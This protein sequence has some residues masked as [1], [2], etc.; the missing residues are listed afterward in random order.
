[1]SQSAKPHVDLSVLSA[2]VDGSKLLKDNFTKKER[3]KERRRRR[4]RK[5]KRKTV[6][7][8]TLRPESLD[9]QFQTRDH[10]SRIRSSRLIPYPRPCAPTQLYLRLKLAA[11]DSRPIL[12]AR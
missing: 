4:R 12:P 9:N 6:E 11:V 2:P 7:E 1:M 8:I 10:P 5:I 3:E